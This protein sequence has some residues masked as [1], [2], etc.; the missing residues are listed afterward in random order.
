MESDFDLRGLD[1]LYEVELPEDQGPPEPGDDSVPPTEVPG[2]RRMP[3]ADPA[4]DVWRLTWVL[5]GVVL[6]LGVMKVA[7][8]AVGGAL[9]MTVLGAA[10]VAVHGLL[11]AA[12]ATWFWD[13]RYTRTRGLR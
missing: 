3:P 7:L 8:F 13:K 2:R 12:G 11:I 4:G 9:A 1:D 6:G 5:L 10:F